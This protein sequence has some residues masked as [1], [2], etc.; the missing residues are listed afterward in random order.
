MKNAKTFACFATLI[1]FVFFP[2]LV[3]AEDN[4]SG[5]EVIVGSKHVI[6]NN[7]PNVPGF[8]KIGEC[9]SKATSGSCR[10]KDKDGDEYNSEWMTVPGTTGQYTWST[11]GGTG[12]WAKV[13]ES[14]WVMRIMAEGS[15]T[16]NRWGG[17]C[18]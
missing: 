8:P 12:K 3:V 10:Y 9:A 11:T 4:C 1:A 14:G 2:T 18:R 6:V 17:E 5:H 16:V 7:D 15:V 13:N